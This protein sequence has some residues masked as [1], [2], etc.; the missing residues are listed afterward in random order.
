MGGAT[1]YMKAIYD[2]DDNYIVDVPVWYQD[3]LGGMWGGYS[4]YEITKEE[5]LEHL[6]PYLEQS[7]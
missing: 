7:K 4:R 6:Q 1:A 2:M 3:Y 5:A